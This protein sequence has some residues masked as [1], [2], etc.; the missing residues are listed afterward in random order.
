MVVRDFLERAHPS[1]TPFAR[2]PWLGPAV[3]VLAASSYGRAM[4]P[5]ENL[6]EAPQHGVAAV[7]LWH[8]RVL[9]GT[10]RQ[11]GVVDDRQV[12]MF[13]SAGATRSPARTAT[14]CNQPATTAAA[15]ATRR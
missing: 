8:L 3:H 15:P 10:G 9:A 14:S 4:R 7:R 6:A 13:G 5:G 2:V 12:G 11:D 1:E